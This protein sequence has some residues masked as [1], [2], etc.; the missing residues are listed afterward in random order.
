MQKCEGY[1]NQAFEYK[2]RVIG[3]QFHLEYSTESNIL[4]FKNCGDEIVDGKYIQNSDKIVSQYSNAVGTQKLQD[5]LLDNI[6][7]S[8]QIS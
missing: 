4:M 2:S 3:L 7:K 5:L 1:A 6:E 8:N